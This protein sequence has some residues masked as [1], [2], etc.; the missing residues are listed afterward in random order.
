MRKLQGPMGGR[1]REEAA[2]G[3]QRPAPLS[4]GFGLFCPSSLCEDILPPPDLGVL[5]PL[6]FY[7]VYLPGLSHV[8]SCTICLSSSGNRWSPFK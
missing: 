5:L 1:G 2:A 4:L 3:S 8:L 7:R 6:N